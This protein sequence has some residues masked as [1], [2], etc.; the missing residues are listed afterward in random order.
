[1][2]SC[3]YAAARKNACIRVKKCAEPPRR[4]SA[5]PDAPE[6]Y[7]RHLIESGKLA[8]LNGMEPE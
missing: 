2:S 8:A 3:L 5:A 7:L 4:T 1:M 6:T